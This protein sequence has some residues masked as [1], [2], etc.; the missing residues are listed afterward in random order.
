MGFGDRLSGLQ[1]L[2]PALDS[3]MIVGRLLDFLVSVF[4]TVEWYPIVPTSE[5]GCADYLLLWNK[6]SSRLLISHDLGGQVLR[7]GLAI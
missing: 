6:Y 4:S 2:T 3:S 7:Q 5:G 1:I